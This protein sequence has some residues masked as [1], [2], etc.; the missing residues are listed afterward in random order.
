MK[1][2]NKKLAACQFFICVVDFTADCINQIPP[3][4]ATQPNPQPACAMA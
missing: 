3:R 4:Q 1:S 2:T